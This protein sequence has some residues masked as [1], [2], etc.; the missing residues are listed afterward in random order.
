MIECSRQDRC[1]IQWY[2][3]RCANM[4][5]APAGEWL[6][7]ECIDDVMHESISICFCDQKINL[8]DIVKCQNPLCEIGIFH[9]CCV[10]FQDTDNWTCD[11]CL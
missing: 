10:V 2:H 1:P 7:D 11:V 9:K 6:C 8:D 4:K 5:A 3:L